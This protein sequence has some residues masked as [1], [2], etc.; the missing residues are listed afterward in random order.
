M[1]QLQSQIDGLAHKVGVP[2]KQLE[3][4]IEKILAESDEMST[5]IEQLSAGLIKSIIWKPGQIES[6]S[7]DAIWSYEA[8]IAPL[9][10]SFPDAV[11]KIKSIA[12]DRSWLLVST[13]GQYAL[14]HPQA[15]TI[16]KDLGLK[17]G[18]S[19]SFVQGKDENVGESVQLKV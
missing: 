5:K 4:K 10:L 11:Q 7:C 15:K 13:T 1:G 8:D 9:G 18:G 6:V 16:A 14:T 3:A 17:G 2:A 19:D 12:Q